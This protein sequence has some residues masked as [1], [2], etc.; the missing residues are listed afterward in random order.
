MIGRLAG[1]V[2]VF[3]LAFLVGTYIAT[4]LFGVDFTLV[5]GSTSIISGILVGVAT[6]LLQGKENNSFSHPES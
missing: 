1:Y 5:L 2:F 6:F 4:A 3:S